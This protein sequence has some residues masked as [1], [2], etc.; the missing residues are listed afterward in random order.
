MKIL[1]TPHPVLFK[2]AEQV[3]KVDAK[4]IRLIDDMKATLLAAQNPKGIGLAAPQVGVAVRLFIIKLND[5]LPFHV[6]INPKIVNRSQKMESGKDLLEGCLSIPKIWGPV[7]RNTQ[8]A[9][10]FQDE[11][12]K[13]HQ[14]SFAGLMATVIQHE[15]DHLDGTLFTSRVLEQNGKLFRVEKGKDGKQE[16]IEVE[17]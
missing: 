7:K 2:K 4:I 8:V 6:F 1:L 15:T 17:I 14:K 5:E 3:K 10:Q 12:G 11:K 13:S 9:V 16:F